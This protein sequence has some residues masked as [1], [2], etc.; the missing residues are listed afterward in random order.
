[1]GLSQRLTY[2]EADVSGY[3]FASFAKHLVQAADLS[4]VIKYYFIAFIFRLY[5]DDFI[6]IRQWKCYNTCMDRVGKIK[7]G[8]R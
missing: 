8:R 2:L 4:Y 5:F 3:P 1:M 6:D 7:C